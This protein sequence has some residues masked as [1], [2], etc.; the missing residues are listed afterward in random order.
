MRHWNFDSRVR[1]Y[2]SRTAFHQRVVNTT[3]RDDHGV[4][5]FDAASAPEQALRK[6]S[7]EPRCVSEPLSMESEPKN[8]F[9]GMEDAGSQELSLEE[10]D[11]L[12]SR[13]ILKDSKKQQ[14]FRV[15]GASQCAAYS[16]SWGAREDGMLCVGI[17]RHGFG[18]WEFIR[19]DADLGMKDKIFLEGQLIKGEKWKNV[20]SPTA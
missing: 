11:H 6:Q 8:P 7:D 15:P 5:G 19:D 16:C 14:N 20:E 1:A 13:V 9:A 4:R 10:V 18:A 12:L 17:L 2:R 3:A